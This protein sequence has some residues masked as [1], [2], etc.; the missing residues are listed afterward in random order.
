MRTYFASVWCRQKIPTRRTSIKNPFRSRL[1]LSL[2]RERQ[3]RK[4]ERTERPANF[5]SNQTAA[6][7]LWSPCT[8]RLRHA[9]PCQGY[10]VFVLGDSVWPWLLFVDIPQLESR[11]LSP[12]RITERTG[13]QTG[14]L[15]FLSISPTC[16]CFFLTNNSV[17]FTDWSTYE[18]KWSHSWN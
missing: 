15:T 1:S 17:S 5:S 12:Q 16:L 4:G 13:L 11:P 14:Q 8:N 10:C 7:L 6:L 18:A 3:H 9:V 2:W